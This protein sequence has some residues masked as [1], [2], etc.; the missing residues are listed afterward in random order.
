MRDDVAVDQEEGD[1]SEP[2]EG[3]AVTC[4]GASAGEGAPAGEAPEIGEPA[5]R[6]DAVVRVVGG[7]S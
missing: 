2:P 7:G 5:V 1:P 4:E 3:A 6:G